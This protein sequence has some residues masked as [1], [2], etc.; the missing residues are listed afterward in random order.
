M[1]KRYVLCAAF[2]LPFLW[3]DLANGDFVGDTIEASLTIHTDSSTFDESAISGTSTVI[4]PGREYQAE[5]ISANGGL[6]AID[7]YIDINN[8]ELTFGFVRTDSSNG[9]FGGGQGRVIT[10]TIWDIDWTGNPIDVSYVGTS[11]IGDSNWDGDPA[12]YA[13]TTTSSSIQIDFGSAFRLAGDGG[14]IEVT[15]AISSVP[16]PGAAIMVAALGLFTISRR[17]R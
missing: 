8:T 3:V 14:G 13:V 5:V 10:L 17:R 16:E 7:H 12:N 9:S 4:D 11:T 1:G 6:L 2:L 15:Y